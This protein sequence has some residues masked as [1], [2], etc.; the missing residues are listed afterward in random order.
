MLNNLDIDFV[1]G[2]FAFLL[3]PV[4]GASVLTGHSAGVVGA[5]CMRDGPI[6]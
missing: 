2:D 4:P 5:T 1:A 3:N 6:F